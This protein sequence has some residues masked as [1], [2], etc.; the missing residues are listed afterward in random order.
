MSRRGPARLA[1]AVLGAALS[2]GATGCATTGA[3]PDG[4]AGGGAGAAAAPWTEDVFALSERA[5]RAYR[6][7]RWIDA[8]RHYGELTDRVPQD[9]WAWFRL[10]NTFARQ[11]DFERAVHAYE[12]SLERDA[13]QPKPWFNLSTAHLLRA[14]AAMTRAW[15]AMRPGD[16]AR[17]MIERRLAALADLM[18]DRIEDGPAYT[19]AVR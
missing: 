13:A 8:A 2:L 9:A 19:G 4:P 3:A 12:R 15:S 14:Q 7:A 17:P 5:D 18:H 6:E 10:G 16:P 1:A 11:G